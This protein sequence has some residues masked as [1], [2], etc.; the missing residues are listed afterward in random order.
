MAGI[1]DGNIAPE[2]EIYRAFDVAFVHINT[3]SDAITPG[4]PEIISVLVTQQI[5]II[6]SLPVA[7]D[8]QSH[9]LLIAECAVVFYCIL[10]SDIHRHEIIGINGDAIRIRRSAGF[11]GVIVVGQNGA[12][13]VFTYENNVHFVAI[14]EQFFVINTFF[15]INNVT[16]G[17]I[18]GHIIKSRLHGWVIPTAVRGYDFQHIRSWGLRCERIHFSIAS[19]FTIGGVSAHIISCIFGQRI[20]NALESTQP[21][22]VLGFAVGNSRIAGCI[23]ANAADAYRIATPGSYVSATGGSFYHYIGYFSRLNRWYFQ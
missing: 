3:T 23:P 2:D 18:I 1:E 7:I 16:T 5:T 14:Q 17:V 15:N 13:A 9:C 19:A 22:A 20:K 4:A 11:T 12:V 8:S 6:I 10:E 21:A